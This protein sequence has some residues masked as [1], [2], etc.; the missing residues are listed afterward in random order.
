MFIS[1]ESHAKTE[2]PEINDCGEFF[3][4][5]IDHVTDSLKADGL[6][7]EKAGNIAI[8]TAV[9][10]AETFSGESFYVSRKP[11]IFARQLAMYNDLKRMHYADVDK[12]HGVSQGYSLKIAKKIREQQKHRKNLT[13]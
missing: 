10:L 1:G 2:I 4:D 3:A 6:S 9:K 11:K 12:K 13:Q 7:E 8:N 5:F